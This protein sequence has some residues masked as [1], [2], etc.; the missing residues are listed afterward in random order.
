MSHAYAGR[1]IATVPS[2]GPA[3]QASIRGRAN[4]APQR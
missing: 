4:G 1:S 2:S 3:P